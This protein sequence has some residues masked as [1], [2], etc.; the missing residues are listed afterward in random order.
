MKMTSIDY[1]YWYC[2]EGYDSH[3]GYCAGHGTDG[4]SI[5]PVDFTACPMITE[6]DV[7]R[8]IPIGTPIWIAE[9]H[10]SIA[11][12]IWSMKIDVRELC[13]WN[14]DHHADDV[15]YHTSGEES[16]PHTLTV[17]CTECGTWAD[18]LQNMGATYRWIV[19]DDDSSKTGN[20]FLPNDPDAVFVCKSTVCL[21]RSGDRPWHKFL[22][23][24]R[25]RAANNELRFMGHRAVELQKRHLAHLRT[26]TKV[27]RGT[28]GFAESATAG[29]RYM[30]EAD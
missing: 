25:S 13:I 29:G 23:D 7:L 22:R 27:R 11:D 1:D 10:A 15:N 8:T 28:D 14:V 18:K 6:D 4:L 17:N 24:L 2:A 19:T 30:Q 20:E 9:S 5:R 12:L 16:G 21:H 26:V 3:C